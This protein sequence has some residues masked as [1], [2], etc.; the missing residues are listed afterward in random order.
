MSNTGETGRSRPRREDPALLTGSARYTDDLTD[1][2][3]GESGVLH[4]AVC[5]SRYG[6]AD[7]ETIDTTETEELDGV[8]AVYTADDV[9][10]S[11]ADGTI[12]IDAAFPGQRTTPFSMLARSRA[13]FTGEAIA[14]VVAEDRYTAHDARAVIDVS[15]ERRDAVTSVEDA[16]EDGAP[17]VHEAFEDNRVFEWEFGDEAAAETA[18]EAADHTVRLD[19][20]NQR[21]APNA[22]EPRAA[23]GDYD[24]ESG[25]LTLSVSTQS[26]H[27]VRDRIAEMVGLSSEH[28]RVVV[29]QVGGGFGSKG[30]SPK[31][32]EPLAAW[33]SMQLG[34][35][36][37]WAGTRTESVKTDP[38][39]RDVYTDGELAVDADGTIRG[40]RVNVQ[41]NA[42]AYLVWGQ[43]GVKH[44]ARVLSGAYDVPA[45]HGK[46]TCAFTNTSPIAPYRGAGRPEG[47]YIVERLVEQAASEL[48]I[49]PAELRRRNFVPPDSFPFETA[50][51]TVYDSGEYEKALD[52]ALAR[53]DYETWRHRQA[54]LRAED[55]YIGIGIGCFV[56]NTGSPSRRQLAR[57]ELDETGRVTVYCGTLDYGQ[58]HE[59]TFAQL[60]ADELGVPFDDIDIKERDTAN[61]EYGTGSSASRSAPD[62]GSVVVKGARKIRERAR[63]IAAGHLDAPVDDVEF[64]DGTFFVA[65]APERTLSLGEVAEIARTAGDTEDERLVET[66]T[67]DP[68][69]YAFS[70][71]THVAVVEVNPDTGEWDFERYVAVDDCGV[72]FNP[73]IVEGQI[74]GGVVQG[75]GQA[76]SEQAVYDDTGTLLTGSLK[77][78]GI[79]RAANVPEIETDSTVTPCPHNPSGA[80]GV[81]ESGAIC[82]PHTVVNAV[83]DALRP[84]GITRIDMP[85]TEENVWRAVRERR[86][87]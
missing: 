72:Q 63:R 35:P 1:G 51:G 15:Y 13:R 20:S 46:V 19:I 21:L 69:N 87:Q 55:R 27:G 83:I 38:H 7:I 2:E 77:D 82:A 71:G 79:P 58:G 8:V 11:E 4:L 9:V 64:D 10:A 59:T 53:V 50:L 75:I 31:A 37:K 56:E 12:E 57:V 33:C 78:Y 85:L 45:I 48:D 22:L 61:L 36:V 66:V 49:D 60:V 18:F 62:G 16:L 81:G 32:G 86:E 42:G 6:N 47:N 39:G 17:L 84:L 76:A 73:L 14:A 80:K 26:P 43:V 52:E 24:A 40:L 41:L 34:R 30:P 5:R 23:V 44:L 28:V 29:P 3:F 54:E 25:E 70:F 68:E 67:Y 65:D 74:R